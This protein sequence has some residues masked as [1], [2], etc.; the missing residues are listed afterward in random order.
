MAQGDVAILTGITHYP[1]FRPSR[2]NGPSND[3]DLVE[4]WLRNVGKVQDIRRIES[5]ALAPT[6]VWS[7]GPACRD[8]ER[9]FADLDKT[10]SA[11]G[12]DRL[13]NRLYL[14]FAGHGFSRRSDQTGDEAAVLTADASPPYIPS[15]NGTMY[16]QLA[17]NWA[18]FRE[19]VLI[20]DCC[21]GDRGGRP[22]V[23]PFE[24]R[25]VDEL[26]RQVRSVFVYA[27]PRGADAPEAA[28]PARQGKV[29]GL[30]THV[31]MKVL[32]EAKADTPAG[33]SASALRKQ[34]DWA[35][36]IEV[37]NGFDHPRVLLGG[38]GDLCFPTRHQGNV[39]SFLWAPQA[40]NATLTLRDYQLHTL[41][42]IDLQR[43]RRLDPNGPSL[44]LQLSA[45]QLRV[46]LPDGLYE[47]QV[48]AASPLLLKVAG[49][50]QD[51]RL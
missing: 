39:I 1:G 38:P 21:R 28:I 43:T 6:D 46:T 15:I 50:S 22:T 5:P 11:L 25:P 12:D 26:A 33:L 24:E 34:L 47:Y 2:L 51:V 35:W 17:C 32:D 31:L 18:L 49:G 23:L 8:F 10:R 41:A 36:P 19:V 9:A 40:A 20:M 13:S 27:V 45:G 37:G 3:L 42:H 44:P 16:A 48:G 7:A 30:L 4:E 29:H 14:Y